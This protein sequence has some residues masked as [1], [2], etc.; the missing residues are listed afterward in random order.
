MYDKFDNDLNR[1]ANKAHNLR[2]NLKFVGTGH[3]TGSKEMDLYKKV[4][5]SM[6]YRSMLED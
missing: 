4:Q 5:K 2:G 1:R 6:I 3:P